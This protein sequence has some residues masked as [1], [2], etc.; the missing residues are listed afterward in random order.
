MKE[1]KKLIIIKTGA[2][3]LA[4]VEAFAKRLGFEP[5]VSDMMIDVLEGQ[6]VIL[7][8]VGAFGPAMEKL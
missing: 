5:V 4:S 3:N 8:G 7:P 1:R 6:V 2:A